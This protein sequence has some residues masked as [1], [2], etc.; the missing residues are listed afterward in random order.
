MA[1]LF[2]PDENDPLHEPKLVANLC[3]GPEEAGEREGA[4]L[5]GLML[6]GV[7]RVTPIIKDV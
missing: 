4:I 5:G 2:Y 3:L 7:E 1:L 6:V